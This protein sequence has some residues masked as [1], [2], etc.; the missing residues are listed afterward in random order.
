MQQFLFSRHDC[1]AVILSPLGREARWIAREVEWVLPHSHSLSR[2]TDG[3]VIYRGQTAESGAWGTGA[4]AWLEASL[5]S[6]SSCPEGPQ[7]RIGC[8]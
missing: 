3:A 4:C 1:V 2:F 8:C 6:S 5:V 7:G